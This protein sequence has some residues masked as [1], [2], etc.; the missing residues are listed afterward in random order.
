[1]DNDDQNIPPVKELAEPAL[2]GLR[3]REWR[4][5]AIVISIKALLFLFAGQS[6]QVLQDQRV[7]GLRGW[8]EIWNRW[9]ALNYQK[10]AQ[11]GYSAT[12]EMRPLLVF[13][14]VLGAAIIGVL[15]LKSKVIGNSRFQIPDSSAED[16][17]P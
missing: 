9:D 8:L 16:Q 1:M 13:Y 5:I 17:R 15:S 14:P 10:L 6:F 2:L 4:L 7:A 3:H 12:G 11:F